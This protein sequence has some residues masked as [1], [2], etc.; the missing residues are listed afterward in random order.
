MPEMT[1]RQFPLLSVALAYGVVVSLLYLF[2]YWSAFGINVLHYASLSDV[3]KLAIYPLFI[4]ALLSF[5]FLFL[6]MLVRGQFKE[7]DPSKVFIIVGPTFARW[8][9][10]G[11]VVLG[12]V[13]IWVLHA[14]GIA[15][16]IAGLLLACIVNLNIADFTVLRPFIS[17][18]I[19]RNVVCF[20]LLVILFSAFGRGRIDADEILKDRN[21]QTVNTAIFK[22][23]GTNEF[24]QKGL[25][26]KHATLKYLGAAG[27]YFFFLTPDNEDAII[28]KYD[29]LHFLSLRR[30]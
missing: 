18:P 30:K 11:A 2:G 1:E 23:K 25:L 27:D 17:N 14:D 9:S 8:S 4:A 19:L 20:A 10:I 15:W 12:L 3:I 22:G 28:V 6:Q 5:F 13:V 29:D 21:V 16:T 7:T 26:D 24:R